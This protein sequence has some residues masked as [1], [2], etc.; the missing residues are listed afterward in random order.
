MVGI[1]LVIRNMV[2]N[3]RGKNGCFYVVDIVL[4]EVDNKY[5]SV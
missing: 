2:M 3:E 5:V 1:M 4:G